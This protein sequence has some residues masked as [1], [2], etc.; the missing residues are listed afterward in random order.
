MAYITWSDKFSVNVREI[1]DQHKI[2]VEKINM[3]HQAMIDNKGREAQKPII[4]AMVDYAGVHFAME[5]K[6][7]RRFRYPGYQKHREE[8]EKFTVKALELKERFNKAG[9]V[10]TLEIMTFLKN[11]LQEHIL[12][13]DMEYV[14]H[15]N[16]NGMY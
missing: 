16:E 12:G 4:D 15:F 6:Y 7:M 11:W 8:H 2:L 9:F 13:T 10:L 5:E 1:D 14:K 3:L